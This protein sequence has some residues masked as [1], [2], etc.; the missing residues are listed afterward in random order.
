MPHEKLVQYFIDLCTIMF[1]MSEN[2]ENRLTTLIQFLNG[3]ISDETVR[4]L[5]GEVR[6]SRTVRTE[7][8]KSALQHGIVEV[9]LEQFDTLQ[10]LVDE[11]IDSG[12]NAH[13]IEEPGSRHLIQGSSFEVIGGNGE[14]NAVERPNSRIL[15]M[16]NAYQERYPIRL[17]PHSNG[18]VGFFFAG[19]VSPDSDAREK[20]PQAAVRYFIEFFDSPWLNHIMRCA[21]CKTYALVN[22]P[23]KSYLYGWHCARCRHTGVAAGS[24]KKARARNLEKLLTR[25]AEVWAK[26]APRSRNKEAWILEKVNDGLNFGERI[27]RNFLT[28]HRAE[29]QTLAEKL[30][31]ERAS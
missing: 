27:R 14:L 26:D 6:S 25:C 24:L 13:G 7:T 16:I 23:R 31:K 5:A 3:D 22:A 8:M 20:F 11:W 1:L 10:M 12:I 29:I 2:K 19:E 9:L 18:G 15:Q 4:L 21:R 28:R 17:E 30:R